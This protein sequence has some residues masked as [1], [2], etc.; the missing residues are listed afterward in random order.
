[1]GIKRS[2]LTEGDGQSYPK[3]G[4]KLT[5]HYVGTLKKGGKK[6]DSSR[7]KNKPFVFTIGQG[8]V[9]RGWDEGVMEMSLGEK[10][11]LEI[12]SDYAYGDQGISGVI[13][14]GATLMFEV[15]LLKIGN[16]TKDWQK[17]GT[18]ALI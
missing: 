1:M 10:S 16:L 4:D 6:F 8:Q 14:G 7:D 3:K 11:T 5:M 13:P 9:I 15:E 2:V 18:C 12:S 17:S